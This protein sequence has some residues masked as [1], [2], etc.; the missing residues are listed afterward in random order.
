[1][2]QLTI[3]CKDVDCIFHLAAHVSVRES[4]VNPQKTHD[5]NVVGTENVY[6]AALANNV[7][8]KNTKQA[9]TYRS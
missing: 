7:K 4:I 1:L 9:P 3:A 8:K 2:E 6:K 5:I